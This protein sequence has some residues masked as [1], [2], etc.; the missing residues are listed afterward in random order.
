[1]KGIKKLL[2]STDVELLEAEKKER[3][4]LRGQL[5]GW[6]YPSILLD[7]EAAITDR[8]K[9]LQDGQGSSAQANR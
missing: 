2:E 4:D 5:V 3:A 8:I 6:L 7:E 9:E 1:V